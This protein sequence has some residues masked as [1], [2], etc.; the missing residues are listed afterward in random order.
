MHITAKNA[1]IEIINVLNVK[2]NDVR[3]SSLVWMRVMT[4]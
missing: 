2:Y 4:D 3:T 1:I